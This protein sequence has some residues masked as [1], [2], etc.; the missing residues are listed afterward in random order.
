M[1]SLFEELGGTYTLAADG[2]YY[3]DLELSEEESHYGKFG[4]I[5]KTFLKEH[6]RGLYT[7][8]LLTGKLTAHLNEIDDIANQRMQ[9]LIGQMQESRHI[10]EKL[11]VTDQ[12]AWIEAMTHI[13]VSAEE[14][15]LNELV[16]D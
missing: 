4:M 3:P 5:R 13:R 8:L 12:F 11:K 16:Y 10:D 1:K 14:M 9:V 2:M 15:V 6:R 7:S